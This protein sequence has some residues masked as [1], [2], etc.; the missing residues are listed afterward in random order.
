MAAATGTAAMVGLIAG[1]AAGP[2][3]ASH[4]LDWQQWRLRLHPALD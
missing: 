3:S 2:F 1:S 4:S